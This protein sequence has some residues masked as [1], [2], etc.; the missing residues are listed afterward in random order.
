MMITI[1]E[2]FQGTYKKQSKERE[3][4]IQKC[5][6]RIA[7]CKEQLAQ[8]APIQGKLKSKLNQGIGKHSCWRT[9]QFVGIP[10]P[11][12]N[13]PSRAYTRGFK[14]MD[15]TKLEGLDLIL[16]HRI[17]KHIF[18]LH[19]GHSNRAPF[20]E[21]QTKIVF[22]LYKRWQTTGSLEGCASSMN[23]KCAKGKIRDVFEH[24]FPEIII[25]NYAHVKRGT[26]L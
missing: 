3:K 9:W 2:I 8:G 11:G 23:Q 14:S 16:W 19:R 13:K 24:I 22:G 25:P 7:W 20:T 5:Y 10:A 18:S 26:P 17:Y 12:V 6:D 1:D 21:A 4:A 15:D